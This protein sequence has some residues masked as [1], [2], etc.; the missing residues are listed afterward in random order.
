MERGGE[1][2][3]E[4]KVCIN[5]EV[6]E[7]NQGQAMSKLKPGSMLIQLAQLC[8]RLEVY[9]PHDIPGDTLKKE[10]GGENDLN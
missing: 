8:L 10:A 4:W 7:K 6:E 3:R 1:A 5:V 9:C 2:G